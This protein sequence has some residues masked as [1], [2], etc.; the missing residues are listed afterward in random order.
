MTAP[1]D[2]DYVRS[3][4]PG[5]RADWVVVPRK[6]LQRQ[7]IAAL[8]LGAGMAVTAAGVVIDHTLMTTA[9]PAAYVLLWMGNRFL[10]AWREDRL[11]EQLRRVAD[12]RA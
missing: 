12:D 11:L 9:F 3:Q 8:V 6:S 7:A 10:P 5:L 2:I 4:F 1:L